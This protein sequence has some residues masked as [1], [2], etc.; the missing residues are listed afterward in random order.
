MRSLD[1]PS[2]ETILALSRTRVATPEDIKQAAKDKLK[3]PLKNS[4]VMIPPQKSG[5]KLF[6]GRGGGKKPLIAKSK[7]F[8]GVLQ[9]YREA[10]DIRGFVR[11]YAR[12]WRLA[13]KA[14]RV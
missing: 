1:L 4:R 5:E 14:S 9:K 8:G 6:D 7:A 11:E 10:G 2:P 13:R 3:L 12:L